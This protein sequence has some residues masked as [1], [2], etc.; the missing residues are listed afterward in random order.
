M[1][2]GNNSSTSTGN[3]PFPGSFVRC[4]AASGGTRDLVMHLRAATKHNDGSASCEKCQVRRSCG[5][6]Y[7]ELNPAK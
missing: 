4:R 3:W 2:N 1:S 7:A 5:K 6:L